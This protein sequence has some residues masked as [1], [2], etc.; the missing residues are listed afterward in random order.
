MSESA[1]ITLLL[2]RI[3]E[4]E[5]ATLER[6]IP[7]VYDQL[8]AI[9]GNQMRKERPDHTL[10]PTALVHEAYLKLV[11]QDRVTWQNRAHFYAISARIMRRILINHAEGRSAAKRGGDQVR[12]TLDEQNVQAVGARTQE[13]MLLNQA[14][15][16]LSALDE[17]QAK[18]VELR[19][20]GGLTNREISEVLKISESTIQRHWS[21]ARAWL[22][23]ELSD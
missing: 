23:R 2:Q 6:L 18:V 1:D 22:S 5:S 11:D 12:V 7:L 13:F 15:D 4:D 14:L 16:K 21:V 10:S 19:Y 20:F 3:N 9:A 17:A 8:R